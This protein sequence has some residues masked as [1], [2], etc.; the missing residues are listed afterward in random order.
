MKAEQIEGIYGL[1]FKKWREYSMDPS[2][3]DGGEYEQTFKLSH[4]RKTPG[5]DTSNQI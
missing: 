1:G 4:I 3:K 5:K 2:D